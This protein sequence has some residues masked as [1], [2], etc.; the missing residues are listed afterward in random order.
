M[1]N[2]LLYIIHVSTCTYL[3]L[4]HC[5][6]MCMHEVVI[7][8][9]FPASLLCYTVVQS[10][11]CTCT[12]TCILFSSHVRK[13][14]MEV[15]SFPLYHQPHLARGVSLVVW[16]IFSVPTY[17]LNSTCVRTCMCVCTV[18]IVHVRIFCVSLVDFFL[19][20]R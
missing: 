6:H 19:L 8:L 3:S 14:A 12:C 10:L 16:F 20:G 11:T 1:C 2:K 17:A 7:Q 15:S 9:Y 4:S 18:C 13:Q 5:L